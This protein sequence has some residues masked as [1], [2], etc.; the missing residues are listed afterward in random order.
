MDDIVNSGRTARR[1][2]RHLRRNNMT[3]LALACLVKYSARRPLLL[4]DGTIAMHALYSRQDLGLP[5]C[6]LRPA[7]RSQGRRSAPSSRS[8]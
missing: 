8:S 1:T 4:R 5:R 7:G 3:P 2:I 6:E